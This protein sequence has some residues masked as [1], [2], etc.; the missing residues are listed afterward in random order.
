MRIRWFLIAFAMIGCSG[1]GVGEEPA[2]EPGPLAMRRLTAAQYKQSIKDVLGESIKVAGRIEPDNRMSGLFGVGASSVSV[3]PSGFEGYETIARSVAEQAFDADRRERTVPCDP[4]SG[5][6]PDDACAREVIRTLGR[7]LFR[8]PL[9]NDEIE[10]RV[11][12]A[13]GAAAV[14]DDFFVGLEFALTSLLVAP[15]FLFRIERAETDPDDPSRQRYTSLTMGPRLSYLLWNTTPDEELLTAAENGDLVDDVALRAQIERMLSSPRLEAGI[16]AFF[17]DW[18]TFDVIDDGLLRKDAELFPA[19]NQELADDAKE[20]TLLTVIDHLVTRDLDY[21]DLFTTRDTFLSR[22][23][24]VVYQVPVG[25]QDGFE[26]F[27]F[28]RESPRAGILSHVSLMAL[29][30][31][32]GQS[33]ATLRGKFVREVLLC[34]DV[35][36]PPG[37]ID[38]SITGQSDVPLNTARERLEVH[39]TNDACSGSHALMDPVGFGLE[40]F[41]SI[42]IFREQENGVTI[43]PSGELDGIPFEDPP[44]LGQ[45]LHDH[46]NLAPCFVNSFYRHAMGRDTLAA[47]TEFTQYLWD[48]FKASRYR[49]VDLLLTIVSSEPFRTT[50]G[51]QAAAGGVDA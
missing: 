20:Q 23:L 41:D 19:Y 16:R 35:P 2:V 10:S 18:F 36:P 22:A 8:R 1:S 32:P 39:Q 27:S 28:P 13:R 49:L 9:E 7:R 42:G 15:D 5:A 43:D 29:Y 17:S 50:S 4:Q 44:S 33:S 26:P 24:G 47:E 3:T 46:P 6:A 45:A 31:H 12:I 30:S 21:R 48:S 14:L 25:I 37:D 38:F 34:Q 11:T 51:P 40:N